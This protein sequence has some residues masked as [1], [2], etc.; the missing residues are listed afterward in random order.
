MAAAALMQVNGTARDARVTQKNAPT[1]RAGAVSPKTSG[2]TTFGAIR[3]DQ[4]FNRV[5]AAWLRNTMRRELGTEIAA[6][7]S[8]CVKV[9][10][11]VSMVRPR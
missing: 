7:F 11:T 9:R 8:S 10:D 3:I 2:K 1:K 4:A 6:E 5:S